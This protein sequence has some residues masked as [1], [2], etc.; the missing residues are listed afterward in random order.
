MFKSWRS[1]WSLYCRV[2]R[3]Q[4]TPESIFASYFRLIACEMIVRDRSLAPMDLPDPSFSDADHFPM[5]RLTKP[6]ALRNRYRTFAFVS[7]DCILAYYKRHF[8]IVASRCSRERQVD[9]CDKLGPF[10]HFRHI[11]GP[12]L[13]KENRSV[14]SIACTGVGIARPTLL[15][16]SFTISRMSLP[17]LIIGGGLGGLLLAQGLKTHNIPFQL[18][19]RDC[20]IGARNQG[21]RIRISDD[22][23]EALAHNLPGSLFDLVKDSCAHQQADNAGTLANLD[24]RTGNSIEAL[25][26]GKKG[27]TERQK[28]N[29]LAA[30]RTILRELLMRNLGES[31]HFGKTFDHYELSEG[32]ITAF[33]QD[34]TQFRGSLLVGADGSYS[35]VRRQL[36]PDYRLVDTEGRLAFGRT[37][38]TPRICEQFS[39]KA[40]NGLALIKGLGGTMVL[41]NMRFKQIEHVT[42]PDYVYWALYLPKERPDD[43]VLL[44]S[45]PEDTITMI[46]DM[47]R[48]WHSS[49]QP[50][51]DPGNTAEMSIFKLISATPSIPEWTIPRVTL[52]GDAIH[53]MAPTAGLG[54]TTS[55][56]D[57]GMLTQMLADMGLANFDTAAR[58]YE[59]AMRVYAAKALELTQ[60]GGHFVFDMKPYDE[61]PVVVSV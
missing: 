24:A 4:I 30:D 18:F 44:H 40:M 29:P 46:Q 8:G 54:A 1:I 22:G 16:P 49:F 55:L 21:Y 48:D 59:T 34:G 12:W 2:P 51:F 11:K 57:A 17:V 35:R 38:M 32:H 15:N 14:Y 5:L 60:A 10:Y 43:S 7:L 53:P 39:H 13:V 33:F 3:S 19:E 47:T 41:E 6:I 58:T 26:N 25:Y 45:S 50:L 9:Q 27:L 31:L 42:P 52:I 23:I 56:K 20:A 36:L 37:P 61:L 28:W